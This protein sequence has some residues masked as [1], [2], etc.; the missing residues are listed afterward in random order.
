MREVY[1]DEIEEAI[2]RAQHVF[3]DSEAEVRLART[4][5]PAGCPRRLDGPR[6]PGRPANDVRDISIVKT[7]YV[8]AGMYDLCLTRHRGN[9]YVSACF[10]V[11]EALGRQRCRIS[12]ARNRK[13]LGAILPS[14]S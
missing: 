13:N 11:A 12:E 4:H 14:L 2:E 5:L 1:E 6:R 7:V 8:I 10:I 3:R 9:E